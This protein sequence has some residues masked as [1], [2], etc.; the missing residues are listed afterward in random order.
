MILIADSGSTKTEWRLI[1]DDNGIL[2]F[3]TLGLN[4]FHLSDEDLSREL[5]EDLL[6]KLQAE[7]IEASQ[8]DQLFFYGA[9]ADQG[10]ASHRM[11]EVLQSLFPSATAEVH[12]DML[13]VARGLCGDQPGIACILGTGANSAYF[14]GT[15]LSHKIQAIGYVLGDEGSGAW[16][17]KTLLAD[18]LREKMP[19]DI[20]R[21]LT[22][23][24][25]LSRE[26]ILEQVYRQPG[27]ARYMASF[28]RF[29]F[30][31][32]KDPYLH[33]LVRTGF[34]LFFRE[35]V[36][37]Y[38]EALKEPVHFSG[39]V[40]FYYANIL[41]QAAADHDVQVRHIVEGPIAGLTLY[42][43]KK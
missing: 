35:N 22:K 19:E 15:A 6:P 14:D 27:A 1:R 31:N 42:H 8:V 20:A 30:Q 21:K 12:S 9:G 5:K 38:P 39:S 41:R 32:L 24:F 13:G 40:A 23:R 18:F 4:P 3:S 29:V 36:L 37:R 28:S 34:D 43:Q 16:I 33:A 26:G 17:G 25:D 11:S 7:N 10:P 2:Q